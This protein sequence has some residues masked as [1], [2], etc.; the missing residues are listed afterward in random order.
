VAERFDQ[1]EAICP[2]RYRQ[3]AARPLEEREGR[4]ER[5]PAHMVDGIYIKII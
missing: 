5:L 4:A 1:R 3:R 2:H